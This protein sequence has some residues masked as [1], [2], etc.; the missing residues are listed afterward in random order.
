MLQ[1]TNKAAKDEPLYAEC[2]TSVGAGVEG[3]H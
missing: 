1:E 2:H 3:E